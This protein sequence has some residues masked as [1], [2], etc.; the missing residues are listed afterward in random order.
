MFQYR[1]YF[2]FRNGHL[3]ILQIFKLLFLE[4]AIVLRYPLTHKKVKIPCKICFKLLGCNIRNSYYKNRL[5]F[6]KQS[7]N[8][9]QVT[10]YRFM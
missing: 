6:E 5:F 1:R 3:A 9:I 10:F 7:I 2:L 4:V 8:S